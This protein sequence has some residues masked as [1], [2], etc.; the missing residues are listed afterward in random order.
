MK[1]EDLLSAIGEV[2]DAYIKKA[3]RKSFLTAIFVFT[4]IAVIGISL[5]VSLMEKDHI[6]LRFNTDGSVNTGYIDPE[7]LTHDKWTSME[8][9]AFVDGIP[10]STTN[11][12]YRLFREYS[13]IHTEYDQTVRIVGSA[14]GPLTPKDYLESEH[15]ANLYIHGYYRTD[16]LDRVEGIGIYSDA[17]YGSPN[18]EL[19]CLELEYLGRGDL[20]LR[21]TRLENSEGNPTIISSRGYD[22]HNGQISGW[23]EWDPENN[24]LAYA[25]YTYN[26]NIQTVKSYLADGTRTGTRVSNYSFGV[27]RWREYYDAEGVL[28]GKEVYRYRPWELFFCLKGFASLV[29]ILSLAATLAFAVWDG[30][31]RPGDRIVPK[32]LADDREQSRELLTE[33][34]ELSTQIA[35]L[36]E[37]LTASGYIPEDITQLTEKLDRLNEN[38]E[39]LLDDQQRRKP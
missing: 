31:I 20:I 9:T 28:T 21:Q 17:A 37:K 8:Q 24:L 12:Q 13:I 38:L 26:G 5:V 10:V 25:E 30:R 6:L 4:V 32:W 16:L 27:L 22:T 7:V 23:K 33:V 1:P 39:N 34:K 35:K 11:I 14:S 36:S 29:V 2:D 15:Y 18:G 3:H 19:N